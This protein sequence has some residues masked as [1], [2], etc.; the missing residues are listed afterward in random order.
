M[1]EKDIERQLVVMVKR[2]GGI[3]P[4]FVSPG[5]DGVPDRIVLMPGGRIGFVEVK[6]PGKKPRK[7]QIRRHVLLRHLGFPVFVLDNP[8][9]IPGVIAALQRGDR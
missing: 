7:L 3:A 4:K 8:D 5:F 2:A 6:A 1:G 9:Q